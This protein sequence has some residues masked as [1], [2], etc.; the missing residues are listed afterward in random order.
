MAE[1]VA[2]GEVVQGD[3]SE[4]LGRKPLAVSDSLF[5]KDVVSIAPDGV[6]KVRFVSGK[7][8]REFTFKPGMYQLAM[9]HSARGSALIEITQIGSN[10]VLQSLVLPLNRPLAFNLSGQSASSVAKPEVA[11][12][13]RPP[14]SISPPPQA[15]SPPP[16]EAIP[17][18]ERADV[19]FYENAD[20]TPLNEPVSITQRKPSS[21]SLNELVRTPLPIVAPTGL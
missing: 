19:L 4:V 10:Q 13:Q 1:A 18:P 12:V 9:N 6:L 5:Q 11:S 14:E 16:Q 3:K 8:A 7:Y 17:L 20:V 21:K 2:I 15:V